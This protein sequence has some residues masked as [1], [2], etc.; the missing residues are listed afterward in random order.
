MVETRSGKSSDAIKKTTII[1][2]KQPTPSTPLLR[3]QVDRSDTPH[4]TGA[5]Q[6][7]LHAD[8]EV[9]MFMMKNRRRHHENI[10]DA[11]LFLPIPTIPDN[12][13][14]IRRQQR[15]LHDQETDD[16]DDDDD[17][18]VEKDG[19]DGGDGAD[20]CSSSS[21]GG[22]A[23]RK[24]AGILG[25]F[26][27]DLS[28][29]VPYVTPS[30][31]RNKKS[32][33]LDEEKRQK[34]SSD[35]RELI[36]HF[37][38]R[39]SINYRNSME[40]L[41]YSF[42]KSIMPLKTQCRMI[43]KLLIYIIF[44]VAALIMIA[45]ALLT[46]ACIATK[47]AASDDE[48]HHRGTATTT[49][50]IN[51]TLPNDGVVRGNVS[52]IYVTSVLPN[53]GKTWKRKTPTSSSKKTTTPGEIRDTWKM[54]LC[55]WPCLNCD[56]LMHACV[57]YNAKG[58]CRLWESRCK[59][60]TKTPFN[61]CVP[62][63]LDCQSMRDGCDYRG[64][65]D[66]CVIFN[67]YCKVNKVQSSTTTSLPPPTTTTK[68]AAS[69]EKEGLDFEGF[70]PKNKTLCKI[71]YKNCTST[72]FI[73][74]CLEWYYYCVPP[75]TTTAAPTPKGGIFEKVKSCTELHDYC[76]NKIP[77]SY[78]DCLQYYYFCLK[79]SPTTTTTTTT[80]PA[81]EKEG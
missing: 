44:A 1:I 66:Q 23:S 3:Q 63:C 70:V 68:P 25:G 35:S 78:Y 4:P 47:M 74:A 69:T 49:T 75:A 81:E 10:E 41:R 27:S 29:Y 16:D 18:D 67:E 77:L 48:H 9:E 34:F 62:G 65:V 26:S 5:D 21:F 32:S 58:A 51:S 76:L 7:S 22:F 54:H 2:K 79:R 38:K 13:D 46:I 53:C 56:R 43:L 11:M 57:S 80:T 64:D 71:L 55:N 73:I 17:D 36:D 6:E 42:Y 15:R 30:I 19:V 52:C 50:T 40:D 45:T 24:A 60:G 12:N 33:K 20:G 61:I 28:S 72:N 39:L 31:I 14:N 59:E 37:S 8:K